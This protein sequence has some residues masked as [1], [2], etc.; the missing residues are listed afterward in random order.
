MFLEIEDYLFDCQVRGLAG[1]TLKNYRNH[2]IRFEKYVREQKIDNVKD[3]KPL[4]IKKFLKLKQDE[5]CT[6]KYCNGIY[7]VCNQ[8]FN[9]CVE[10]EYIIQNPMQN[11]KKAREEKKVIEVFTDEEVHRLINYYDYSDYLNARNKAIVNMMFD[12]GIRTSELI[13]ITNDDIQTDRI[14]IFGKGSKER[15]VAL[16][17]ELKKVC[18]RYERIK[19]NYFYKKDIPDNYFLSRTGRKLTVETI[20]RI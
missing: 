16:S 17:V 11:I 5:G 15:F 6:N 9:Y 7:K 19:D 3:I 4:H 2:L 13:N 14:K 8:F 12:T 18:R 20:E 10:N 1:S